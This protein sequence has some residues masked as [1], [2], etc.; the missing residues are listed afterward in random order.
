MAGHG[1]PP[2]EDRAN[3][4][5]RKVGRIVSNVAATQP[6][7]LGQTDRSHPEPYVVQRVRRQRSW[8]LQDDD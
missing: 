2:A 1:S 7:P 5:S 8:N 4:P 3:D 6:R